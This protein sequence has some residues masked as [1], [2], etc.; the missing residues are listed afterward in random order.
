MPEVN[1]LIGGRTFLLQCNEGEEPHLH[2]AAKMLDTEASTLQDQTGRLPESRMLLMAGLM[3]AD[4]FKE[5]EWN[6]KSSVERI[7]SLEDQLRAAE[8]KIAA[9]NAA[10]PKA[11]PDA[12]TLRSYES[13]IEKLEALAG[14]LETA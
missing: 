10:Q 4:R 3:L 9:L 8:S 14:K 5:T 11:F 2:A 1:V 13:A 12:D 6:A 7:K